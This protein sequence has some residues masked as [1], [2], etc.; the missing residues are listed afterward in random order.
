M[1]ARQQQDLRGRIRKDRSLF[2]LLFFL[3]VLVF[4]VLF[5]VFV[6]SLGSGVVILPGWLPDNTGI[7]WEMSH[8]GGGDKT[9][10]LFFCIAITSLSSYGFQ[11]LMLTFTIS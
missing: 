10:L 8:Y 1:K 11:T 3:L 5:L 4:W 9:S 2:F 6:F 7:Q